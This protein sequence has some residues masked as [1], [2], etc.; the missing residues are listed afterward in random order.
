MPRS[1]LC[2]HCSLGGPRGPGGPAR[3]IF[4]PAPSGVIGLP[5]EAPEP[6][7]SVL[8]AWGLGPWLGDDYEGK[9]RLVIAAS[10][11]GRAIAETS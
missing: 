7:R 10:D 4:P 11:P 5:M 1:C 2:F 3:G 8:V 6:P 9:H